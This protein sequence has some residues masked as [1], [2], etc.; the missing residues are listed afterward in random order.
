M[1]PRILIVDDNELNVEMVTFV[2]SQAGMEVAAALDGHSALE[3]V[4]SFAPDLILMDMQLPGLDGMALTQQ[5]R[6]QPSP[7]PLAIVAFT[8]YAM[9][10]DKE[11][12][13][14]VGC[15][16]YI[17][18]PINVATFAADVRAQL[19]RAPA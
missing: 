10:G 5:L 18:K 14:A 6:S 2:L 15:D 17:A 13:L 11:K 9:M 12:F 4:A 3:Q 19:P 8:A 7:R 16:G 1:T